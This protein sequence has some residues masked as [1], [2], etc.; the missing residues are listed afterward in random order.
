MA[1]ALEHLVS[2][3]TASICQRKYADAAK[4]LVKSKELLT[5]NHNHL[6]TLLATL[7][8]GP[9]TIAV[10]SV[11]GARLTV[12]TANDPNIDTL[13]AMV[14]EFVTVCDLE[15]LIFVQDAMCE[16]LEAYSSLLV[17]GNL[18]MRGIEVMSTAIKKLESCNEKSASHLTGAHPLLLKLCLHAQCLKPALSLLKNNIMDI[19]DESEG[20]TVK[21]FLMYHYYGGM[22]F[23]ALKQF[24][25]ALHFFKICI[26]TP[27]MAVSH[28]M[29]EAYKKFIIVS[30]LVDGKVSK[31]PKCSSMVVSRFI[32]PLCSMYC[33]LVQMFNLGP[34]QLVHYI[35]ANK[36]PFEQDGNLGLVKQLIKCQHKKSIQKLTRTFLTLSLSDVA[37]RAKLQ[38][39]KEAQEYLL[40]MIEDNEIYASINQKDGM[41]IFKDDPEQYNEA[42]T[43]DLL[44]ERM[45]MVVAMEEKL[46][47][48]EEDIAL[49]PTYVNKVMGS[50]EEEVASQTA[51]AAV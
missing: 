6:D 24:D 48:L 42:Q 28:I 3:V 40:N 29:M 22:V 47:K 34:S 15:Q 44:H 19:S 23:T 50:S 9:H 43:L 26:C 8:P 38:Y 18:A 12:A 25:R 11:L 49:N 51:S 17:E 13:H 27:A 39:P 14:A 36:E 21:Q 10:A 1:T 5:K 37:L 20:F 30:I 16:T 35:S 46:E 4:Q 41:V 33:D 45:E 2:E 32:R 7:L 31:L